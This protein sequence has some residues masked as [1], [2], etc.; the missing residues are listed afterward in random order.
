MST[1]FTGGYLPFQN[2]NSDSGERISE[3]PDFEWKL[4]EAKTNENSMFT[5][6][7]IGVCEC[8]E[9]EGEAAEEDSVEEV[10]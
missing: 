3:N 4:H 8:W 10:G 5:F 9:D 7:H 6:V 1:T 2:Q